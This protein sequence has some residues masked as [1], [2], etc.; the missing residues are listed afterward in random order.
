MDDMNDSGLWAQGSRYY[1]Q[2]RVV[3]DTNDSSSWAHDSK[4][5]EQLKAMND[6]NYSGSWAEGYG[7]YEKVSIM[8]HMNDSRSHEV[9]PIDAMYN[10]KLWMIW[11]YLLHGLKVVDDMNEFGSWVQSYGLYERL[12][13]PWAQASRCYEQLR[14]KDNMN[15]SW[16]WANGFKCYE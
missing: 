11:I 10:S 9:K 6:I 13:I 12:R 5:Y 3:V 1:E 2:L 14:V 16:S 15:D 4:C 7:C 8:H